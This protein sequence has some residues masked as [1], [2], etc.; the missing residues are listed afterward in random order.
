MPPPGTKAPL[1][2]ANFGGSVGTMLGEV[3]NNVDGS[4][5][6]FPIMPSIPGLCLTE[7]ISLLKSLALGVITGS[8]VGTIMGAVPGLV[9]TQVHDFSC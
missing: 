2:T 7:F 3:V 5:D 1:I 4:G 8:T 6:A 9:L